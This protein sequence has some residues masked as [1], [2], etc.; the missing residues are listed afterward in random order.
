MSCLI[1]ASGLAAILHKYPFCVR[2]EEESISLAI[3]FAIHAPQVVLW[4]PQ[5]FR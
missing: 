3:V 1:L 5:A 2:A 4:S